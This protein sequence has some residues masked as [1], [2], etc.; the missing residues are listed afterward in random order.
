MSSE[1]RGILAAV[2]AGQAVADADL[3]RFPKSARWDRDPDF[4]SRVSRLK[5]VRDA[6]AARLELDPG[7]LCSRERLESIARLKP[8]SI[9]AFGE[10]AG[11]RR[12]GMPLAGIRAPPTTVSSAGI[13]GMTTHEAKPLLDALALQPKLR[14]LHRP[15]NLEDL[16]LKLTGRQ[17]RAEG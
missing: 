3:P 9:E 14:T 13:D 15:A 16:F 8:D 2:R 5:T 4:E 11:L 7:V 6:A 1:P 10:V 17:I 12:V